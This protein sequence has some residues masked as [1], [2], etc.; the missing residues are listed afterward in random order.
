[1]IDLATRWSLIVRYNEKQADTIANMV[2]QTQLCIYPR[3]TIITYDRG[4][5]FLGHAFKNDLIEIEYVIKANCTT[6]ENPQAKSILETIHQVISNLVPTFNLQYNYLDEDDPQ[7]GI[8]SA[9]SFAVKIMYHT[10][11]Q[12]TP[13]QMVLGHDMILNTEFI[14]DWKAISLHKQIIINNNN[15]LENKIVNRTH[16]EYNKK[17]QCIT[18]NKIIMRSRTQALI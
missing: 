1:M 9:T 13:G 18:K 15:Q 8:L 11:L 10:T 14:A 2:E 3:P 5:K 4:N 17:Y 6:T 12:V 7:S 16:I